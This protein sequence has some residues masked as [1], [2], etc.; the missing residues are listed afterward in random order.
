VFSQW[1]LLISL[2]ACGTAGEVAR[3]N[4]FYARLREKQCGVP[5]KIESILG[6]ISSIITSIDEIV[7]EMS[8]IEG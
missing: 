8:K 7:D 4:K 2:I 5:T 6:G 1:A 3:P